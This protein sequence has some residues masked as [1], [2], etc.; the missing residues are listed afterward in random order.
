MI[1][2]LESKLQRRGSLLDVGCGRRELLWA[3][4][5]NAW[6]FEGLD[7]SAPYLE[8][9]RAHL[10][11]EA[12]LG[13]L[14]E[15]KFSDG[16][17]DVVIMGG[18]IEHLYEPSWTLREV[19]RLLKPGGICYLDAPNED[20]LYTK[21]GNLYMRMLGRDWVVNLAPTFPPYHVQGFNP[22][23][24]RRVVRNAGFQVDEFNVFG[25]VLP[26]T[27]EP[28]LRKSIEHSAAQLV[29]WTGNQM[30]AGI[31]MDVWL[32]KPS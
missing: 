11:I 19:W 13:T 14:E 31:Y 25:K 27:G 12:H 16:R 4:R 7:P 32:R 6:G 17:F 2:I 15:V 22:S 20:G 3:A 8:W 18:V 29:N 24:L 23:S 28:S 26:L 21:M 10:G 9:A 1:R 5:Q 30:G